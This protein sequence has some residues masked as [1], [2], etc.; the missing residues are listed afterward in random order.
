MEENLTVAGM[1]PRAHGT[2]QAAHHPESSSRAPGTIQSRRCR[3]P[4]REK[5]WKLRVV[6]LWPRGEEARKPQGD[7]RVR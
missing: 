1:G 7:I 6:G 2:P 4:G 5:N 3:V